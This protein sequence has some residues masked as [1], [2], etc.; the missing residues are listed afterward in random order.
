MCKE[1]PVVLAFCNLTS[2]QLFQGSFP[3]KATEGLPTSD[4][5]NRNSEVGS[6][7]SL[8]CFRIS[9]TP[10]PDLYGFQYLGKDDKHEKLI[11]NQPRLRFRGIL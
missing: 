5:G 3:M 9:L 1:E 4:F 2:L 8:L 6:R 11:I 10:F 7:K